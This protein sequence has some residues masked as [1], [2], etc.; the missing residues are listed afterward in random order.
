MER[1]L[2]NAKMEVSNLQ[3]QMQKQRLAA[4]DDPEWAD[5]AVWS[6]T[7]S[8]SDT[9]QAGNTAIDFASVREQIMKRSQGLFNVPPAWREN[10]SDLLGEGME[11]IGFEYDGI[12]LVLADRTF[13]QYLVE[14]YISDVSNVAPYMDLNDFTN[15]ANQL[16]DINEENGD[17]RIP[18]QTSRSWLSVFFA[19]LALTAYS[20]QDQAILE[21]YEKQKDRSF[22]VGWDF[23]RAAIHFSGPFMRRS[24]IN[25]VRAALTLGIYFRQ[26]N[27]LGGASIWLGVACRIGQNIGN[28][29]ICNSKCRNKPILSG[30]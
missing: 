23:A 2:R 15:R 8:E 6:R 1:K 24:S 14:L 12:K 30:L 16:Y 22:P 5:S 18:L 9:R 27:E 25:D 29:F 17:N 13:V 10:V 26:L 4:L 20:I 21:Y 19:T 3:A 11:T 7:S 28:V